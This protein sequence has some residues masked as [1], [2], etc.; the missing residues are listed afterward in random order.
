MPRA[1]EPHRKAQATAFAGMFLYGIAAALLGAILPLLSERLEIGLGRV[2][3]L[4]LVLNA[5]MLASSFAA[6]LAA[7]P[8][9]HE[10]AARGGAAGRGGGPPG[11]GRGGSYAQLLLAVALLGVGGTALN[12]ASNA[13]VADLFEDPAAKSAAL[14]R[15]GLFFGFGALLIPFLIGLL[16]RTAGLAG[17]LAGGTGLCVLVAVANA[18]PAYP[19]AKHAGG[20]RSRNRHGSSV[21]RWCSG[22]ASCC[23]S[24]PATSSSSAATRRRS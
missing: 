20:C 1:R 11:G 2:G 17:I 6:R 22:S 23:S 13:L 19:P 21:I 16:L 15:V 3:T 18:V 7:G 4:F 9:R 14:N 12:G 10:A 5:C 24:S 8:P